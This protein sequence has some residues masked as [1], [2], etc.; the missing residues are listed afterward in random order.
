LE[1]GA[2]DWQEPMLFNSTQL[3]FIKTGSR[4]AKRDTWEQTVKKQTNKTM[5][6][7]DVKTINRTQQKKNSPVTVSMHV[8]QTAIYIQ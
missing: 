4:K 2:A 7:N 5:K 1:V 6:I 3:K 8:L